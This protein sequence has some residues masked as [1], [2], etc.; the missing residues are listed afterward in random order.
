MTWHFVQI[1]STGGKLHKMSNPISKKKNK[2]KNPPQKIN[3]SATEF[4]QRM[5]KFNVNGLN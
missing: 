3:L 2:Q 1:V 5:V 4:A